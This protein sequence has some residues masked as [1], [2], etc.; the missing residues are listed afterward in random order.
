M[1]QQPYLRALQTLPNLKVILGRFIT[2]QIRATLVRPIGKTRTALVWRTDEKGSDVNL[3]VHLLHD[4]YQRKYDAAVVISNDSDLAEAIRIVRD[5]FHIPVWVLNPGHPY[6]SADLR[7]VSSSQKR[8]RGGV[9]R[10]SQ[11]SPLM[12]DA[13]GTFQKPPSW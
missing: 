3:A 9:I 10:V 8:V 5:D 1:R 13:G 6:T 4:A 11:F 7:K 2:K 12:T